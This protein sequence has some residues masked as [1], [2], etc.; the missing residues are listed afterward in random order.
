MGRELG[1]KCAMIY[2]LPILVNRVITRLKAN[3]AMA[4][5]KI[6]NDTMVACLDYLFAHV[7]LGLVLG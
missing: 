2:H 5:F 7:S 3:V 1:C 4:E 6:P